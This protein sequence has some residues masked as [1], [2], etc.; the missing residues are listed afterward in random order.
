MSWIWSSF[1][2]E[3]FEKI[4]MELTKPTVLAPYDV[5]VKTKISSDASDYG[6]GPVILQKQPDS[7]W[8]PVAYASRAMSETECRYSPIE[9][10]ALATVWAC[11]KFAD[12]II[13]KL[14]ELETDHKPLVPLLSK[15]SLDSLPPRVL[16]FRLRLA[17]FHYTIAHVP[18][19][20]LYTAD[21]LSRAPAFYNS[22]ITEEEK[23]S[24]SIHALATVLPA[25]LEKRCTHTP[26]RVYHIP[27]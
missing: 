21:A 4:K 5:N 15:T 3:A 14:I 2:D 1:Q 20:F 7:D 24:C 12:Y 8:R 6:L 18:G 22:P 13:G 27:V 9:K 10:E 23:D 19:K 17:R 16:R 26:Q 11:E 25:L